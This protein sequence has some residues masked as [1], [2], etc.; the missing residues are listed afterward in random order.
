[1]YKNEIKHLF[2]KYSKVRFCSDWLSNQGKLM[3][4][5][6]TIIWNIKLSLAFKKNS[7]N[8][9][10]SMMPIDWIVI[11]KKNT[12][13]WNWPLTVW[14]ILISYILPELTIFNECLLRCAIVE[15]STFF[16]YNLNDV[17][18]KFA[19]S[20]IWSYFK[21]EY[22]YHI[23]YHIKSHFVKVRFQDPLYFS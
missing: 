20:G 12:G 13:C 18:L 10:K 15:V 1:M 22:F 17:L 4:F 14:L 23:K 3:R 19:S 8:Y 7:W 21:W 2:L 16:M 5:F 6:L 11:K 9:H